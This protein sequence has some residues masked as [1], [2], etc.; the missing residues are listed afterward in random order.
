MGTTWSLLEQYS[1]NTQGQVDDYLG[2][3][4]INTWAILR[5]N[6][7][8][9]WPI[10]GHYLDDTRA[11]LCQHTGGPGAYPQGRIGARAY[12]IIEHFGTP[13]YYLGPL[14]YT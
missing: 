6:L 10:L 7:V 9:T 4:W 3:I 2:I 8:I 5:D 13:P 1:G 11:K 14:K 12:L